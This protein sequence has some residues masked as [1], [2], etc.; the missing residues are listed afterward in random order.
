[1]KT[2]VLPVILS[3]VMLITMVPKLE[4]RASGDDSTITDEQ[5]I[6]YELNDNGTATVLGPKKTPRIGQKFVIP[7]EINGYRVTE[8]AD[9]AFDIGRLDS[10]DYSNDHYEGVVGRVTVEFQS[11]N[12]IEIIGKRAFSG[13]DIPAGE[14]ILDHLKELRNEAFYACNFANG[15]ARSSDEYYYDLNDYDDF[16]FNSVTIDISKS[17]LTTLGV[18][19]FTI[20]RGLREVK[21]PENL[22]NLNCAFRYCYDL[23]VLKIPAGVTKLNN[24]EFYYCHR[25]K[26]NELPPELTEIGM[27]AFMCCKNLGFKKIPD[28]VVDIDDGAFSKTRFKDG[29]LT[30]PSGL[31]KINAYMFWGSELIRLNIPSSIEKIGHHMASGSKITCINS[32]ID[33][34]VHLPTGLK[35]IGMMAFSGC[36]N[37]EWMSIPSSVTFIGG[38]VFQNCINLRAINAPKYSKIAN[39]PEGVDTIGEKEDK[40]PWNMGVFE[41]CPGIEVINL[42]NSLRRIEYGVFAGCRASI[43]S[44]MGS[45]VLNIPRGVEHIGRGAFNHSDFEEVIIPDSVKE[46]GSNV[47]AGCPLRNIIISPNSCLEKIYDDDSDWYKIEYQYCPKETVNVYI[48]CGDNEAEGKRLTAILANLLP[49]WEDVKVENIRINQED[50]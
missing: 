44:P 5:G 14:I 28:S 39:I 21:L 19:A 26:L 34:E 49:T 45:K 33:G 8:I 10:T 6:E 9:N 40:D 48:L 20:C 13:C 47:F 7:A 4:L 29:E 12:Y 30:F 11:P 3:L 32:S 41:N 15:K 2:K 18:N 25:V 17:S 46:I 43:N 16:E 1:M 27:N 36:K 31:D 42:P 24:N 37:I 38:N 22:S 50:F 23:E 35:S